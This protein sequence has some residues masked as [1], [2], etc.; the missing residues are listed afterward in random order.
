MKGKL[1][2]KN[3][4]SAFLVLLSIA[5]IISPA[6][7][8]GF[9]LVYSDSG[10]YIA[11]APTH[12]IPV[13]R[14]ISYS[15]FLTLASLNLTLWMPIIVQSAILFYLIYLVF[16]AIVKAKHSLLWSSCTTILLSFTTSLSNYSSQLMP[17]ILVSVMI[18]A[19]SILLLQK[20]NDSVRNILLGIVFIFAAISHFSIIM[21]ATTLGVLI[22]ILNFF[23]KWY[24]KSKSF[25]LVAWIL[26]SWLI[27]PTINMSYGAGFKIS[28][29]Q[30]VSIL[31]RLIE[32]GVVKEYLD[33]NCEAKN[34]SLCQYKDSLPAFGYIF[35]WE[36]Y[37]P[38]YKGNCMEPGW[39]NCWLEKDKEYGVL[40]KDILLSPKYVKKLI[41]ISLRDTY[42]QAIDFRIGVL[43]SMKENSAPYG[44]IKEFYPNN[45]KAYIKA[46]QFNRYL[47]FKTISDIQHIFVILSILALPLLLLYNWK[48]TLPQ[49]NMPL[50]AFIVISGVVINAAVCSSLSTVVDRY[51][52]RVIWLV[53]FLFIVIITMVLPIIKKKS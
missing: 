9:P 33:E 18:L 40:V 42:R 19:I 16:Q 8:N 25:T 30:N 27:V 10:T 35:M 22:V 39:G 12:S 53:P 48:R 51:Q 45:L 17:D 28:R 5:A 7:M 31:G 15:L 49:T 20:E 21:A 1:S 43:T 11:A 47:Y 6:L 4:F 32:T 41:K 34:Y 44:T 26:L 23:F 36:L 38:L 29:C 52:S 14:P 3:I 50:L 46:D 37:S 24:P 13:D 2:N